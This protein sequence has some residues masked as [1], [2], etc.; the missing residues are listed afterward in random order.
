MS[1][2]QHHEQPLDLDA[3]EALLCDADGILFGS[4]EP[5]FDA[6]TAVTNRFLA[7]LGV[8]RSF[9]P[10]ELRRWSMGRNFRATA[11]RLADEADLTL[12]PHALDAWVATEQREVV[13]HLRSTLRPD[14][15]VSTP[16]SALARHLR[17]ALVSSSSL[18]RLDACLIAADL[19]TL[20][21]P[22]VRFSAEDSL[23]T[24]TSKPDPAIYAFA[25]EQLGISG[26]AGLAVE[27]SVSGATSA[28]A[29][30]FPTV[31]NLQFVPHDE[32]REQ[33]EALTNAGVALV[34]S[35]W[36]ALQRILT[37]R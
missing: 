20:F 24:P 23:P 29:A 7:E 4:E 19:A 14:P 28:V 17:L 21:P 9:S 34:V 5:A 15:S 26:P 31:G 30:G 16:I 12:E 2:Q 3:V 18:G 11:T 22:A 33:A 36:T 37:A 10:D 25:S 6:S 27:D 35:S 13:E 32:R 1:V 8:D